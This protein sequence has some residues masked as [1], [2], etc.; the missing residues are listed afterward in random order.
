MKTI[1]SEQHRLRDAKTELYG[2][3]LVKPFERPSRADMVIKAVRQSNLGEIKEP[4]SYPL[5]PVLA[6]HDADFVSFLETAWD[7]WQQV[8]YAGEAMA[9]VWPARRMQCRAPRFI[10]G[11]IG[12][13]AMAA[14]TTITG[15]LACSA[16]LQGCRADWGAGPTGR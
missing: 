5:D 11:K 1:Y 6:V 12:Y 13:Y 3:Q 16:G 14:E 4:T 9:T 15:H 7:E 10:E 8:G 2:G